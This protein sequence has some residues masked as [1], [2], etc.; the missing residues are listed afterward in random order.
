MNKNKYEI[1]Q[2]NIL[3]LMSYDIVKITISSW[4]MPQ[5]SYPYG[6]VSDTSC[7]KLLKSEESIYPAF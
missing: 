4:K 5:T 1:F 2:W 7:L 3:Y 6:N